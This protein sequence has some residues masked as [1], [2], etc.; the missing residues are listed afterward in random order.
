MGK[1]FN[2]RNIAYAAVIAALYVCLTFIVFP[3]A[4]GF[5]QFRPSEGLTLLPMI[6]PAS[7][8]GLFIG[9]LIAN[10][11]SPFGILDMVA[12]SAI[13]LLAAFL[14]YK[15]RKNIILAGLPPVVLNALFVPVI[16]YIG[17]DKTAYFISFLS[18]LATQAI[19]VYGLGIPVLVLTKRIFNHPA[20]N[21][22]PLRRGELPSAGTYQDE[23]SD[24]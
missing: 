24:N 7:I 20:A 5:L 12:G 14:T 13:T 15:L 22:A 3:F 8:P 16:L 18:I 21:A 19:M 1:F 10:I 23:N 17:G 2:I 9:C 6:M 4:Y 11:V